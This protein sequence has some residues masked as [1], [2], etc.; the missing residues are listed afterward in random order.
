MIL[1]PLDVVAGMMLKPATVEAVNAR[2]RNAVAVALIILLVAESMMKLYVKL[3]PYRIEGNRLSVR[4]TSQ[5]SG[6]SLSVVMPSCLHRVDTN[7]LTHDYGN[8][9]SVTW[10]GHTVATATSRLATVASYS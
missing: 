3:F 1:A 4:Y 5:E 6:R 9:A 8:S 10:S 2:K 7:M